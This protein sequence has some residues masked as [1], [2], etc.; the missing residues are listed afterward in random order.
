MLFIK[1]STI[2][3]KCAVLCINI[4]NL[5]IFENTYFCLHTTNDL[6]FTSLKKKI[7]ILFLIFWHGFCQNK[8]LL[9]IKAILGIALRVFVIYIRNNTSRHNTF[10]SLLQANNNNIDEEIDFNY[11]CC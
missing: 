2:I 9:I 4:N 1:S 6:T 10:A 3:V 8:F 5:K 11:S 7:Y